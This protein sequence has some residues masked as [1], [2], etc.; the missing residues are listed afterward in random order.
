VLRTAKGLSEG[1]TKARQ[2]SP[3]LI[4]TNKGIVRSLPAHPLSGIYTL[5]AGIMEGRNRWR[6]RHCPL[7]QQ[8]LTRF[9][10]ITSFRVTIC[11]DILC[12]F[13]PFSEI[14][15][16]R[17]CNGGAGT[18]SCEV[19]SNRAITVVLVGVPIKGARCHSHIHRDVSS[20]VAGGKEKITQ[21][22]TS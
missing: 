11:T 7:S 21:K 22:V 18:E 3:K 6:P 14:Q 9:L 2:G 19:L 15:S 5:A 20:T 12:C 10:H 17:I 13:Y 8:L 1:W 4:I 16:F